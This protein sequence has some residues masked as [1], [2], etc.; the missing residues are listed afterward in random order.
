MIV[1]TRSGD[2]PE[3]LVLTMEQHTATAGQLARHF[4][5]VP[6]VPLDPF[7]LLVDLVAEHDRG[8]VEIDAR[9]PRDPSTGLPWSIYVTP[10]RVSIETGPRSVD[11]NEACHP[12]RGLLS[13]MHIVGLFTGRYGRDEG[14]VLDLLAPESQALLEPMIARERE[15]QDRL[16]A[17]LSADPATAPLVAEPGPLM[18]HYQALQFFDRLALWLQV[19][20]PDQRLPTSLPDVPTATGD[21]TITVTPLARGRV[22]LSPYPFDLDPLEVVVEGRWLASQPP[23]VDLARALAAAPQAHQPTLLTALA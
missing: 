19:T 20:H 6:F 3:H 16:R 10:A 7:D 18:R 1:Q 5:R 4:G 2:G 14:A 17:E 21:V 8:W 11:H 23:G 9:A 12:Y 22:G 15:R 13:S